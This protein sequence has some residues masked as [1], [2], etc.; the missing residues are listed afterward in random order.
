VPKGCGIEKAQVH[1][2]TAQRNHILLAL[3]ALL[4]L[5]RIAFVSG[6]SWYAL[7]TNIIR[8]AVTVLLAHPLYSLSFSLP[9]A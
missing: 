5:E 3:R 8:R 4:R 9:T 6:F 2:A 7:K 1:S